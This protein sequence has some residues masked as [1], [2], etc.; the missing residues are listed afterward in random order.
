M[1]KFMSAAV[2][3]LLSVCSMSIV[4]ASEDK[5]WGYAGWDKGFRFKSAD[6]ENELKISNRVQ[7]RFTYEDPEVGDSIGS[8]QLRRWKF[9][10]SG[11]IYGHWKYQLQVDFAGQGDRT[12]DIV[13][14]EV[15]VPE[16]DALE[17]AWFQ[18]TK[19]KWAQPWLGQGK[20]FFG[21]Q[22]LTSS[23]SLQFVDRALLVQVA[24]VP[25]DIGVGLVGQS[26]G[27]K[28]EYNV[29]VYNGNSLNQKENDNNKFAYAGRV[30]W[31]PFGEYKLAES[32]LDR[33]E[34]VKLAV[35]LDG[36][37]NTITTDMGEDLDIAVFGFEFA[38]KIQGFSTVSEY[39]KT[40]RDVAGGGSAK[41]DGGYVQFGYLFPGNFEIAGRYAT[42]EPDNPL[43]LDEVD[44]KGIA[45]NYY[46]DKHAYKIQAD[47]RQIEKK[48]DSLED[49]NVFRVQMQFAF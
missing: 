25:R 45:I 3:V 14:T 2:L 38:L 47:Y 23:G 30:V 49:L 17:D 8:F 37:M 29:G 44:S 27:K 10:M 7:V 20:V 16:Q 33:P 32:A 36:F 43:L 48:T 34:S 35:G 31:T 11:K 18:Y 46:F 24:E 15:E 4:V 41:S 13:G 9:K 40:D 12:L 22:R 42:I 39:F 19:N 28:F 6:G 21:R 1:R 5:D 26:A